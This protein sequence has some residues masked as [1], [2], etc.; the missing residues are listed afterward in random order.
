MPDRDGAGQKRV[1][2]VIGSGAVKCAAALGLWQ[3]F[4]EAGIQTCMAVGCSG[5]SLFASIMALGGELSVARQMTLDFWTN[6]LLEGYTANLRAAL[7]GEKQFTER[8]GLIDDQVLLDRLQLAFGEQLFSD[9]LIPLHLVTTDLYTGESVVLSEGPIREAV[10]ASLAIPMI[11]R[12]WQIGEQL[13][14]D[15]AVSN[16]LPIDVAIKHGADIIIAMGFELTTRKRMRSYSAMTAHLNSLYMNNILKSSFAFSAMAHHAEVIPVMP[17][18][19]RPIGTFDPQ[20]IPYIIEEG[21]RAAREQLP[22]I[23]RLVSAPDG[24]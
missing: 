15:G 14:V 2:L 3:V 23:Q 12:P 7:S 8:S 10:R 11:Y 13:L 4:Q 22:Y 20:H 21:A 18:F 19:D 9:T 1:A 24:T 16:P 6:E 17:E 5:G